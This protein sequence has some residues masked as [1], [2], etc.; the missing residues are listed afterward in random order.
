LTESSHGWHS[1]SIMSIT[2]Q[3]DLPEEVIRE[4][5]T[6]GLLESKRMTA[7]LAEEVSRCRAGQ[8]LKQI[9]DT[10]RSAPGARVTM[11]DINAEIKAARAERRA[12]EARS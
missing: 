1:A 7:L 4:A 2:V 12:R 5:R 8:E 10:V 9:L 3:L 6:F 11:E